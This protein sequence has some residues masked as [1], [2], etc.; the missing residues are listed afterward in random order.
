MVLQ[1]LLIGATARVYLLTQ[2]R[3]G[4]RYIAFQA[5]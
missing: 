3:G 2:G 4:C 1:V 5:S